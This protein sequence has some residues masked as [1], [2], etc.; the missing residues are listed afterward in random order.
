MASIVVIADAPT[1]SMAREAGARWLPVQ[2]HRASAALADAAAEF[3][4]GHAKNI[5]QD[6]KQRNV[7]IDIHRPILAIDFDLIGHWGLSNQK[8]TQPEGQ[9]A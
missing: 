2:M 9:L 5:A 6:P 1:L 7:A 3:G 4:A 8:G